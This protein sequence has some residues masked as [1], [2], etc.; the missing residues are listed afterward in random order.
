MGVLPGSD[1][2]EAAL[3]EA[4]DEDLVI[5][6]ARLQPGLAVM[7]PS[8]GAA[9][10]EDILACACGVRRGDVILVVMSFAS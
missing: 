10:P 3:T 2:T 8:S 7:L 4:V 6:T 5:R 1:L 9:I